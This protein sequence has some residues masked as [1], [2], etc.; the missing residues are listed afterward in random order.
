MKII[1]KE[2]DGTVIREEILSE[3]ETVAMLTNM[4]DITEWATNAIREKGRRRIDDIVTRSGKGSKHT[5][6]AEKIAIIADMKASKHL[7]LKS[8]KEKNNEMETSRIKE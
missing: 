6:L 3:V 7:L 2:D 1:F 5:G 4:T 8:A